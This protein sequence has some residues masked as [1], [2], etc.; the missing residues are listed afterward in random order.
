MKPFRTRRASFRL[1]P[2]EFHF[3]RLQGRRVRVGQ[4]HVRCEK[5]LHPT[6]RLST[7]ESSVDLKS[8]AIHGQGNVFVHPGN[9][10]RY[11][12]VPL[13]IMVVC[14]DKLT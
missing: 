12:N 11:S 1:P 4:A 13:G 8:P 14:S 6:N 7:N 10:S 3:D 5:G 2:T 9:G